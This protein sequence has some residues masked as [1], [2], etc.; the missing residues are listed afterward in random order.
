MYLKMNI[1]VINNIFDEFSITQW[2]MI[3]NNICLNFV[4]EHSHFVKYTATIVSTLYKLLQASAKNNN[5][6]KE[7]CPNVFSLRNPGL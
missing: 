5:C 1:P 7:S 6:V 2:S 3:L 4:H